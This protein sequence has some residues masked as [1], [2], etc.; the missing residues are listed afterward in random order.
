MFTCHFEFDQCSNIQFLDD[1]I[2]TQTIRTLPNNTYNN[3]NKRKLLS[4]SICSFVT[5]KTYEYIR[6]VRKKKKEDKERKNETEYWQR[7]TKY[8]SV[9]SLART[10]LWLCL[11]VSVLLL[12]YVTPKMV[13]REKRKRNLLYTVRDCETRHRMHIHCTH[14]SIYTRNNNLSV[15]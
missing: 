2:E 1:L 9:K 15:W 3:N 8:E 11:S 6:K 7:S 14:H 13:Y 5:T 10:V 12:H 4:M